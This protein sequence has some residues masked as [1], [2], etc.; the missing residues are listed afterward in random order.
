MYANRVY[1]SSIRHVSCIKIS[2]INQGL[3]DTEAHLGTVLD[4][5]ATCEDLWYDVEEMGIFW[6]HIWNL[7]INA[8]IM[9]SENSPDVQNIVD[10]ADY[11]DYIQNFIENSINVTAS[12]EAE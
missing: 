3:D 6:S 2:H 12:T 1:C 4:Q 11:E 8:Q 5:N 7:N 10:Y 9:E